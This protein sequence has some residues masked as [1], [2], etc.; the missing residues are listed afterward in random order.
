VFRWTLKRNH[1]AA[2]AIWP[3][4]LTHTCRSRDR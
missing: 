4:T 2:L 3:F 1:P